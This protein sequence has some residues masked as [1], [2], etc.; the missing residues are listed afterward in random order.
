MSRKSSSNRYNIYLDFDGPILDFSER[1]YQAYK[2]AL[3]LNLGERPLNRKMYLRRKRNKTTLKTIYRQSRGK[4]DYKNFETRYLK[5]IED[6]RYLKFDRLNKNIINFLKN[7]SC[8]RLIL[9]TLRK[10][11]KNLMDELRRFKIKK[12]FDKILNKKAGANSHVIKADLIHKDGLFNKHNSIIIGD[13]EA[14]ILAGKILGIRTA[15]VLNGI[16]SLPFLR[17]LKPD[18]IV[19]DI[20]RLE[21]SDG[22]AS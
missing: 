19:K 21:I 8:N 1:S 4:L 13:T 2:D 15:A 17:K 3:D 11:R 12:Y 16:R 18:R 10:N 20:A 6:K 5:N 7:N 9:V 22:R 14:D